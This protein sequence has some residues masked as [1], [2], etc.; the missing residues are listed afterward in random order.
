[1]RPVMELKNDFDVIASLGDIV[2]VLKTATLIQFRLFHARQVPRSDFADEAQEMFSLLRAR[3][4]QDGTRHPFFFHRSALPSL[5][6]IVSSEE[7][8]LGEINTLLINAALDQRRTDDDELVVLGERGA[9]YLEDLKLKFTFFPGLSDEIRAAEVQRVSDYLLQAYRKRVGRIIV[10]YPAFLSLMAQ[11][12]TVWEGLPYPQGAAADEPALPED[13]IIEPSVIR[14]LEGAV[15]L[16]F[17]SRLL[18]MFWSAKLAEY[19][20]RIMHLEGSGQEL[21]HRRQDLSTE[22][23]RQVHTL[24]DKVIREITASRQIAGLR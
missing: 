13:M 23:F 12:I 17:N 14:V 15:D 4:E 1:M 22:Y 19:A 24:R 3:L 11:K 5:V 16:W 18:Q 10:V 6:V 8:F 9:R 21:S 20:A 7:G 2:D